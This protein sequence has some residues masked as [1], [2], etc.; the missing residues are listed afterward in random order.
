MARPEA[1]AY[2]HTVAEAVTRY[3][4]LVLGGGPAGV[5][6]ALFVAER[7]LRVGLLEAGPRT[8]GMAG[9]FEVDGQRVDHGSHRLHPATPPEL[10]RLLDQLLDGDLQER[11]RRGRLHLAGRW[12]AFPLRPAELLRAMPPRWLAGLARDSALAPMRRR[13]LSSYAASLRTSLG[14]TAYDAIYAPYARKLWGLPGEEIDAEQARVRVTADSPVRA[15]LRLVATSVRRRG[16]AGRGVTFYYPRRGFGQ[17]T[18]VLEQAARKAGADLRLSSPVVGVTPTSPPGEGGPGTSVEVDLASGETLCAGRV[19]STLPIPVLTRLLR[20]TDGEQLAPAELLADLGGLDF[21]AMV[22]VYL[23]HRGGRWSDVDAHYLP[24]PSTPVTRISEPANYRDNEED[25]PDR[26]V[27]CAEIPCRRGDELWEATDEELA[28]LVEQAI[29]ERGLPPVDR[30]SGDRSGTGVHV[31][32]LPAVYPVYRV[33]YRAVLDRVEAW[34]EGVPGVTTLGRAGL[35]AH[36]NTHHGIV[37]ARAAARACGP[38]GTFDEQAWGR[39][40]EEFR[41]HVVED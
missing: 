20:S 23:T 15:A 29:R 37:M 40:R 33:G 38:G 36:D 32:R 3:D 19:L 9:S 7:G 12:L 30:R 2:A 28:G 21:R 14:V 6:T 5:A 26:S 18:E 39:A 34:V 25:P 17:L 8:G 31:R 27:L 10:L 41:A 1:T 35:F 11:P 22:L 16:K 4:V 13:D 24:G